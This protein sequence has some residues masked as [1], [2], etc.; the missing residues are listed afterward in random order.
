MV[1]N[2]VPNTSPSRTSTVVLLAGLHGLVLPVAD[3][4]FS[5]PLTRMVQPS[6]DET[7]RLP[8]NSMPSQP[9]NLADPGPPLTATL[10]STK[11]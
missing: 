2:P 5:E 3:I 4:K 7:V 8:V 1:F 9:C 6:I 10:N 11:L